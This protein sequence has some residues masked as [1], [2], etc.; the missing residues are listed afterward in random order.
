VTV[1]APEATIGAYVV[2][3]EI[4][5]VLTD[6]LD[7]LVRRPYVSYVI[8]GIDVAP[9]VVPAAT[10]DVGRSDDANARKEGACPLPPLEGA[11]NIKFWLA[12]ATP[13]PPFA[14]PRV[15]YEGCAPDPPD[16]RGCPADPALESDVMVVAPEATTGA[17]VVPPEIGFVVTDALD[18]LVRRPYVSYVI[19]GIDVAPPVVPAVTPDVG[20]SDDANARKDGACPL[21]PLEGAANIKF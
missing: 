8:I 17:Y 3:P 14:T 4:G 21:P 9:P 19:I 20:R 6:A 15:P 11:A 18:T 12:V 5:F 1:V 7:T 10:P 16:K 13:V 2:P